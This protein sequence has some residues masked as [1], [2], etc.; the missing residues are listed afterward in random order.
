MWQFRRPES[1]GPRESAKQFG[2]ENED[3]GLVFADGGVTDKKR[4]AGGVALLFRMHLDAGYSKDGLDAVLV[5]GRI[6]AA[7]VRRKGFVEMAR[8]TSEPPKG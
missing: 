5:F 6:V 4:I 3:G 7:L 1:E 8:G 2:L